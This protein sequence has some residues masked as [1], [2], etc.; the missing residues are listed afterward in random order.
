MCLSNYGSLGDCVSLALP[1]KSYLKFVLTAQRRNLLEYR[2]REFEADL[3]V[4]IVTVERRNLPEYKGREFQAD[5]TVKIVTMQ[6][7]NLL[8]YRGRECQ[9]DFIVKVVTMQRRNLQSIG[10]FS[11][12]G[13][14]E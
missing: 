13:L 2:G 8:E 11:E 4:K 9:A 6:R 7:R 14:L 5:F 12:A 1:G 3:I 10:R